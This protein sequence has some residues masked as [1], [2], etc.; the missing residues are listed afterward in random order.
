MLATA[1]GAHRDGN[2]IVVAG[3]SRPDD[4]PHPSR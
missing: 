2:D 3:I 4:N 1:R